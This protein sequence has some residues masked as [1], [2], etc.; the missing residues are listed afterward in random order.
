MKSSE[1]TFW[2]MSLLAALIVSVIAYAPVF[3]GKI[4]FPAS[5]VF[6]FPPFAPVMPDYIST[7]QTNTGDLVTSFYPYRT[8][9]ARAVRE[10]T[11]PLWNPYML[12]GAPFLANSQSA[13]F[14]PANFLYYILPV[15]LAWSIGF[16][17]RRMLAVLF[18]ALFL[19]RAGATDAG[20]IAGGLIFAFCGFLTAW[21]GQA[22]SDG[23]VWL[24][25]MCYSVM[26]LHDEPEA[27]SIVLAAFTFSMPVFAGHPETAAHLTL[28]AIAFAVF[29][30]IRQPRFAFVKAFTISG[31]LAVGL[32]AVQI[33]PT[34]E[35]LKYI[36]HS[37]KDPWP[38]VPLWS[39]VGLVSRDI[40]RAKNSA[41][42]LMP[43]HA[44]YIPMMAFV[45]APLAFFRKSSRGIALFFGIWTLVVFCVAFSIGPVHWIVQHISFLN[46]L[47][48]SRLVLVA[49]FGLSVLT[50][51][52]ISALQEW[53][54]TRSQRF[55]WGSVLVATV[56]SATAFVLIY[57]IHRVPVQEII[58]FHRQPRFS[59]FLL[60]GSFTLVCARLAVGLRPN[61]FAALTLSLVAVDVA[62]LSYGAISFTKP[63]DVFPK[64]ELFE[65]L[66]KQSTE[67][68][69]VV[70]VGYAYGTNFELMY[71]HGAVGGYELSLERL[72]TFLKDVSRDEMD[73]VMLTPAGI[74]EK[75]DRRLDMLNARYIIVSEWD[76]RYKDFRQQP[77]RFRFL[78]SYADTDVYENLKTFPPAYLVPA[79]GLEV[80]PDDTV[81][82][83]R[84]KDARFDPERGVIVSEPPPP[85]VVPGPSAPVVAIPKTE[86]TARH[87]NGFELDVSA[88]APSVLVI[89]Q[90]HYPGWKAYI[91]GNS[92]PV[93]RAN[94]A[95]PAIFIS[96]GPHHVRFSFEPWTFK[97][98]LSLTVL[99]L[100][101]FGLMIRRGTARSIE[102]HI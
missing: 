59:L 93:T 85:L 84:L 11:L 62:S 95:F 66:P 14:Y 26:R 58:E 2:L 21:Q 1:R 53:H 64:I 28:T 78:Y 38:A 19:R 46:M 101:L 73:S 27:F 92:V 65:R 20:A 3:T 42:L 30:L 25:L 71:G 34:V 7:I 88:S 44:S 87:V 47:K 8:L 40:V 51:L 43:E 50:G 9:A 77:E 35:W 57:L 39:I 5:L 4:P 80:I 56:G 48:N 91:D 22:M 45:A 55:V 24:P 69:R 76:P 68:Y 96:P 52:G 12:S 99:T 75:Q 18:T 10:G 6:D 60:V 86:W 31:L 33:L 67:P 63:R 13:L 98:G 23:A 17:V 16:F 82:L 100:I 54:K 90:I 81:Q 74:L 49:S 15:P 72:K 29:V 83:E 102:H 32:A 36:H 89:S 37:L 41:G 94:Y 79:S 70:Q 97:A 61:L